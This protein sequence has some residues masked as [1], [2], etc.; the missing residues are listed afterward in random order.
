MEMFYLKKVVCLVIDGRL[1]KYVRNNHRENNVTEDCRIF[2]FTDDDVS[3]WLSL[4]NASTHLFR[5]PVK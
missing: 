5:K 2:C 3:R 4:L 1:G